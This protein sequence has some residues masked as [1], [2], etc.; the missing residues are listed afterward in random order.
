MITLGT[1]LSESKKTSQKTTTAAIQRAQRDRELIHRFLNGDE[2]AFEEIV[3]IHRE[4]IFAIVFKFLHNH[5]DS[6]EIVQD[7]FVRAY[8]GLKFFRE[9]SSLATWLH[10]IALNLSKNRYW[11]FRR[12][13]IDQT[14]SLDKALTE[15]G[16]AT[17]LDLIA[18]DAM[19]PD[20]QIVI[21]EFE[22]LVEKCSMRLDPMRRQILYLR[23]HRHLTYDKIGE[24]F[25]IKVGTVKSKLSRARKI[26]LQEMSIQCPELSTRECLRMIVGRSHIRVS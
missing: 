12:R 23:I 14:S 5:H 13:K 3:L 24:I 4:K 21:D 22:D 25:G 7:V 10:S 2:K 16:G 11:Y 6:Q 9:D 20:Q 1:S 15:D 17:F 26:L 19:G 8:K 18:S